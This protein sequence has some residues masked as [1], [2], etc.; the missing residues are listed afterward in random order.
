MNRQVSVQE[1]FRGVF[2]GVG[3]GFYPT[4]DDFE[5]QENLSFSNDGRP[6]IRLEQK[7]GTLDGRPLHQEVGYI[8]IRSENEVE[9]LLVQ[10]TGVAE[11]SLGTY[12]EDDDRAVLDFSSESVV[13]TRSALPVAK[14]RRTY[15]LDGDNL[16]FEFHMEAV[17]EEFQKHLQ[18][19]LKK[20]L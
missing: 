13:T 20:Q 11:V 9:L 6:F 4:I 16:V 5:Y 1:R 2:S 17:G 14:T 3:T 19:N 12:W 10:P 18:S 8:R 15:S 7:T